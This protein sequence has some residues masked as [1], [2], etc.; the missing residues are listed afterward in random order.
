MEVG[1]FPIQFNIHHVCRKLAFALKTM[2][3]N[4]FDTTDHKIAK[5]EEKFDNL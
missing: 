3:I 4:D 1:T 2:K 5:H